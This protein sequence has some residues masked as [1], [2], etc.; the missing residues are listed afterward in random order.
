LSRVLRCATGFF[1]QHFAR[2]TRRVVFDGLEPAERSSESIQFE[3][4]EYVY[5]HVL[6]QDDDWAAREWLREQYRAHEESV[7][8]HRYDHR[9]IGCLCLYTT[10]QVMLEDLLTDPVAAG[11]IFATANTIIL[12][13]RT[14]DE[15]RLGRAMVVP[16]HRGSACSDAIIPYR[17][18]DLGIVME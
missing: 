8:H 13:G 4:M 5:H 11:D 10:P 18:S 14:L 7:M 3:F 1:Y 12:M 15:G 9:A 17:V 16:K 6:R 2:G